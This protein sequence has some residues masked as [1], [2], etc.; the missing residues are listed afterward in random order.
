MKNEG[1]YKMAM[2]FFFFEG[3]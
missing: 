3:I 2:I 1:R